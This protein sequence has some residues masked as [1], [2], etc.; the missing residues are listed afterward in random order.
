MKSQSPF[1]YPSSAALSGERE[2][3]LAT[4]KVSMWPASVSPGLRK[5][6]D[7]RRCWHGP[8]PGGGLWLRTSS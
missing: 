6:R 8:G 7:P 1:L 5:G 2:S 3:R 4:L